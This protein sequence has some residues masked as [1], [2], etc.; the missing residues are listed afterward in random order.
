[1]TATFK[2]LIE[3]IRNRR[4]VN[5][6]QALANLLGAANWTFTGI[7]NFA[8]GSSEHHADNVKTFWGTG[9]DLSVFHNAANSF[10]SN[11]TGEL[12]ISSPAAITLELG[13]GADLAR[14]TAGLTNLGDGIGSET[15]HF[16]GAA[17]TNRDF[18]FQ[19]VGVDRWII[20]CDSVAE[21]GSNAGSNL[22]INR[23]DDAGAN[24]GS[25]SFIRSSGEVRFSDGSSTTNFLSLGT[26]GDLKL[27]HDATESWITNL[28][29]DLNLVAPGSD[30]IELW[31]L[32]GT[33]RLFSI[34]D[35]ATGNVVATFG[36]AGQATAGVDDLAVRLEE[37]AGI[38]RNIIWATSATSRWLMR[39][40]SSAE[41]GSDAGSNFDMISFTDAGAVLRTDL[42]IIRSSGQFRFLQ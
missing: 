6:A 18:R 27:F 4:V 25:V 9:D 39:A 1:M 33:T 12:F 41:S 37:S 13:T 2:E 20:R 5:P 42:T 28:T 32:G 22:L 35:S 34:E 38:N 11:N 8:A 14:F 7:V 23:R 10:L 19:T 40:N 26:G 31:G 36:L 3:G 29:G 21:S 24:L 17:A 30:N 15:I 16:N